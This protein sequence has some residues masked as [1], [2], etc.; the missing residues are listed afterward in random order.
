MILH[1]SIIT[2]ID[3]LR[4][5]EPYSRVTGYLTTIFQLRRMYGVDKNGCRCDRDL[6]AGSPRGN[7]LTRNNSSRTEI[8]KRYFPNI[9]SLQPCHCQCISHRHFYEDYMV[10]SRLVS[11]YQRFVRTPC[12]H[13]QSIRALSYPEDGG[14]RF[15]QTVGTYLWTYAASSPRNRILRIHRRENLTSHSHK[16]MLMAAFTD[17]LNSRMASSNL[18]WSTSVCLHFSVFCLPA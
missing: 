10:P 17:C 14:V 16:H 3:A 1:G 13:L 18:F 12:L 7:Q 15:S 2:K 6:F 9:I 4:T 5:G 8:R 11:S